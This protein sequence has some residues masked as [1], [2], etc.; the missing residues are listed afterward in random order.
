MK[1]LIK[2]SIKQ[3]EKM[4]QS[5]NTCHMAYGPESHPRNPHEKLASEACACELS[6]G[7]METG[8]CLDLI[9]Q[10]SKRPCLQKPVWTTSYGMTLKIY[11]CDLSTYIRMG[12][13][14]HMSTHHVHIDTYI[15]KMR[16]KR[17]KKIHCQ[18][19]WQDNIQ[20]D[21]QWLRR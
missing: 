13:H 15:K 18:R 20:I 21:V 1:E 10:H 3:S 17:S 2:K 5:L 12:T 9:G 14:T 8:W 19:K 4:A 6:D 11:L 16:N 7:E